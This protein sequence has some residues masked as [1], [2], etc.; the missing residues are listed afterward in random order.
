MNIPAHDTI[1]G[2]LFIIPH[3][4][5]FFRIESSKYDCFIRYFRF[6]ISKTKTKKNRIKNNHMQ[7]L[8]YCTTFD[9]LYFNL[10]QMNLNNAK[11]YSSH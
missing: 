6:I 3:T 8:I 11:V 2:H 7:Q 4:F 9:I 10:L 1:R 5:I